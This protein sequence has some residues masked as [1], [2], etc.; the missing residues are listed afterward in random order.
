MGSGD[1][2]IKGEELGVEVRREEI[3]M[4]M[5]LSQI[6]DLQGKKELNMQKKKALI[7][8]VDILLRFDFHIRKGASCQ[9]Y[10]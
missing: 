9:G 3:C 2:I 1:H 4:E 5:E 10:G 8:D 7:I 6:P